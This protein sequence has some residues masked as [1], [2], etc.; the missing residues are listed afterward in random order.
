MVFRK[1]GE[2][3]FNLF[4]QRTSQEFGLAYELFSLL[5]NPEDEAI[6]PVKSREDLSVQLFE[7]F[8]GKFSAEQKANFTYKLPQRLREIDPKID[9]TTLELI[10]M[11]LT[12]DPAQRPSA[13]ECLAHRFFSQSPSVATN[14]EMPQIE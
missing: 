8:M 12:M 6:W 5:G 9:D 4:P 1:H 11:M 14:S 3:H 7:S 2:A 13:E 10:C